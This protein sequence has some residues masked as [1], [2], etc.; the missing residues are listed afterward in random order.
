MA[1]HGFF[2]VLQGNNHVLELEIGQLGIDVFVILLV[3]CKSACIAELL[4]IAR[5]FLCFK[6][7]DL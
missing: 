4:C 2:L 7:I 5:S 3:A 1:K 6:D